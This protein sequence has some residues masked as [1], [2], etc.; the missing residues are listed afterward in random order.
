MGTIV[1]IQIS[2]ERGTPKQE[3]EIARFV[4]DYGI[5]GDAH[6]GTWHRQVSL[7]AEEEIEAFKKRGAEVTNGAFGENMIV[8]DIDLDSLK[9]GDR[10]CAG[11]VLLEITQ[12]GK[13]CHNGC[14][15]FQTMGECIM[16]K[17]GV[18][19]KVLRG[20]SLQKDMEIFPV[21]H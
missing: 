6:A 13:E 12:K 1:A 17:K 3:T 7:L 19:A 20:G 14:A 9:I 5:E 10:L 11:E 8:R 2:R 4:A 21:L 15:I 16:P 18:F